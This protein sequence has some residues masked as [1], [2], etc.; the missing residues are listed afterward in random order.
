M[1]REDDPLFRSFIEFKRI[2]PHVQFRFEAMEQPPQSIS[3]ENGTMS[4][5]IPGPIIDKVH[6]ALIREGQRALPLLVP[7]LKNWRVY[8]VEGFG[9]L[10]APE[11]TPKIKFLGHHDDV[12]QSSSPSD[13]VEIHPCALWMVEQ[14][15]NGGMML[16]LSAEVMQASFQHAILFDTSLI[17]ATA[18]PSLFLQAR[19]FR[20]FVGDLEEGLEPLDVR[21]TKKLRAHL[22]LAEEV[23]K[24]Y[25]T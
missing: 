17:K 14:G 25:A 3:M 6:T 23:T 22:R 16:A 10:L 2:E 9:T 1:N 15:P 21:I 5:T 11:M 24:R 7:E 12:T 4:L 18:V 13:F 8:A 19:L 20:E